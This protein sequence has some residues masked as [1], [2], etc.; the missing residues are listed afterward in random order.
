MPNRPL[1]LQSNQVVAVRDQKVYNNILECMKYQPGQIQSSRVRVQ[2]PSMG[3]SS[4]VRTTY[5]Q[6]QYIQVPEYGSR[7]PSTGQGS[8]VRIL[9]RILENH[10]HF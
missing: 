6:L 7:F 10:Q 4:Q 3:L 5:K 8:Q 1:F 2:V 9:E